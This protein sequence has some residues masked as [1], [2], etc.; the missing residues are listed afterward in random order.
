LK[1]GAVYEITID[2]LGMD[3]IRR[4]FTP[5]MVP[6]LKFILDTAGEEDM[7]SQVEA[8]PEFPHLTLLLSAGFV[9]AAFVVVLSRIKPKL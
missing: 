2:I 3:S 7:T 1:D 4:L 8:V 9:L 6:E 5:E